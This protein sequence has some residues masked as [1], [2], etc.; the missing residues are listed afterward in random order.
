MEA[1]VMMIKLPC[2]QA[3]LSVCPINE[4]RHNSGKQTTQMYHLNPVWL[5]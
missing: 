3:K 2:S 1:V 4:E 5:F